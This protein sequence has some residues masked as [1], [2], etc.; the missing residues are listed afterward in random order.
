M[1]EKRSI[2]GV[3][4]KC[5][6]LELKKYVVVN[7]FTEE[8]YVQFI[9]D[10]EKVL[11]TTQD[12]LPIVID[13]FGGFVYSLLGMVDFLSSCNTKVITICESKCMS[14]G[15]VLFSC[16]SERYIGENCTV[17]VHDVASFCFGKN[18]EIQ[19]DAKETARLNKKIYNILDQN[20]A[21][22]KGYWAGLVKNNK[23]ADLYMTS[24][25]AQ[26]HGLATHI[27]VPY[28]E[29]TVVAK[30]RLVVPGK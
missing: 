12:F 18:T 28:I 22:P 19:N 27:G 25:V 4:G 21:Q 3:V 24:A 10:C 8:S 14:C 20:T 16:G 6:F 11:N 13:S 5:E 2:S 23:F 26:K 15:A 29:T 7:K 30:T 9:T 1:F 17:M